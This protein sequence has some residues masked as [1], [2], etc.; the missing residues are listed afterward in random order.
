[1]NDTDV[2]FD[3]QD[4]EAFLF[5]IKDVDGEMNSPIFEQSSIAMAKR[6]F[7]HKTL[8]DVPEGLDLAT[9][10]LWCVGVRRKMEIKLT[11]SLEMRGD[12]NE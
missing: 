4:A 6:V 8:K 2:K 10:E 1:M 7:K 12:D 11:M 5:I 9:F 3:G